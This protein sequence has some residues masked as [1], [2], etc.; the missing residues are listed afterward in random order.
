MSRTTSP[1][2]T[3]AS[4]SRTVDLLR[5]VADHRLVESRAV[6]IVLPV[7]LA[8]VVGMRELEQAAVRTPDELEGPGGD[9]ACRVR[10]NTPV[11]ACC[12]SERTG[13]RLPPSADA[14]VS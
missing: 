2:F 3:P 4:R 11:S 1:A 9:R 6:A 10:G 13:M 7:H 12:P 14:A 8:R 5:Q